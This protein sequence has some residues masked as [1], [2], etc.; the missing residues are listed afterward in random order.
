LLDAVGQMVKGD[1]GKQTDCGQTAHGRSLPLEQ[2]DC[3]RNRDRAVSERFGDQFTG[4]VD[5]P[6]AAD[7]LGSAADRPNW[8]GRSAALRV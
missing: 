6:G 8:V 1:G 3:A 7:P 5:P 4:V 2:A